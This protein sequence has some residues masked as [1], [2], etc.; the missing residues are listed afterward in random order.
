MNLHLPRRAAFSGCAAAVIVAAMAIA[1]AGCSSGSAP[2]TGSTGAHGSGASTTQ[3]AAHKA[4]ASANGLTGA[5]G[6]ITLPTI[7][8]ALGGAITTSDATSWSS[9]PGYATLQCDTS[10]TSWPTAITGD[11]TQ[12][13]PV[14]N[15]CPNGIFAS[16]AASPFLGAFCPGGDLGFVGITLQTDTEP[17]GSDRTFYPITPAQVDGFAQAVKEA[18]G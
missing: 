4:T 11:Y 17:P 16:G 8:A 10:T 5:C 7:R 18:L 15:P 13:I 1:L 3:P 2:S 14:T 12:A 6:N 9:A